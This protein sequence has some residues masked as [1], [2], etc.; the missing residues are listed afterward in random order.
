MSRDPNPPRKPA[1]FALD[2]PAL[3]EEPPSP[4]AETP[5]N[6]ERDLVL[7]A[8]RPASRGMRWGSLFFSALGGLLLLAFTFWVEGLVR[9]LTARQDWLGWLAVG[10]FA[11]AIFAFLMLLLREFYGLA[12]L[13]ALTARRQ[14]AEVALSQ[15]DVKAARAVAAE[16]RAQ[17]AGR[18]ELHRAL[19]RLKS[20][21]ADVLDARH[22]LALTER[23]VLAPLDREARQV[24]SS[25]AR[26]VSV[27][28]AISP[29]A[30][31][32]VGFVAYENFR[33]LRRLASLYGGR[34]GFF[35]ML[36]L[37]RMVAG[38]LAVTGGLALTDDFA[39]QLIGHGL[40]ARLS[41]RLGEGMINGAFTVRIGLAALD[42]LR[43][44]PY[45]EARPPKLRDFLTAIVTRGKAYAST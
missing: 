24:V 10:L 32:D 8:R 42:V 35:A 15:K 43:P 17:F 45:V 16:L 1:M 30:A 9:G 7:A 34:P 19:A 4:A 41:R 31:V 18:P 39:Q 6:A 33:M 13:S 44:L 20:F 29:A 26:R 12:R 14:K 3:I 28:T 27:V 38:H 37:L 25:A 40:T 21:D 11:L 5:E 23:E 2:D 36:R 22:V